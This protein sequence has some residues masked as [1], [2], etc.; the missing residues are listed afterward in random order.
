LH[1][2]KQ[3][4]DLPKENLFQTFVTMIS[5]LND[6]HSNFLNA[7]FLRSVATVHLQTKYVILFIII[8]KA[9]NFSYLDKKII[10]YN[11]LFLA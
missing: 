10:V 7:F 1:K 5:F 11:K 8:E 9:F 3:G 6:K 2:A 4:C